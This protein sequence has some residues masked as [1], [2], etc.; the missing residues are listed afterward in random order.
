MTG[1]VEPE[2][3]AGGS[4]GRADVFRSEERVRIPVI[5]SIAW[6]FRWI[7]REVGSDIYPQNCDSNNVPSHGSQE[8]VRLSGISNGPPVVIGVEDILDFGCY[9]E[10]QLKREDCTEENRQ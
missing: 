10:R 6:I 2:R 9:R 8:R 5:D 4:I 3:Q 1:S 7:Y